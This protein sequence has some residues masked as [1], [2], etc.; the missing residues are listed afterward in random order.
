MSGH[1]PRETLVCI[2][3]VA[4]V[5]LQV[6]LCKADNACAGQGASSAGMA[7]MASY[8]SDSSDE[9]AA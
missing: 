7:G 3:H 4:I 9:S 8:T 2:G 6:C 1:K 5:E